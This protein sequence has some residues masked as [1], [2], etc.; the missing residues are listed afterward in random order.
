MNLT[1]FVL[2]LISGILNATWNF[3]SKKK[4]GDYSVM[5]TGLAL[6]H[7]IILP[8]TLVLLAIYGLDLRAIPVILL[9]GFFAGLNIL[10]L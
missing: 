1:I 10:L 3:F 5:V 9:S 6:S 2:T 8:V 4:S 7:L